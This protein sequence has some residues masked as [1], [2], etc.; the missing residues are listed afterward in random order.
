M[1]LFLK[2]C[3]RQ[4]PSHFGIT[5]ILLI[6]SLLSG[7]GGGVGGTG[8]GGDGGGGSGGGGVGGTGIVSMGT[9]K[10][11]E[12]ATI[13]VNNTAYQITAE[14]KVTLDGKGAPVTDLQ[15]G[16]VVEVDAYKYTDTQ[17]TEAEVIT[18]KNTL[19]GPIS[20]ING[21]CGSMVVLGQIIEADTHTLPTLVNGLCDYS[22]GEIVEVSGYVSDTV[23]N[24]IRATFIRIKAASQKVNMSGNI[25]SVS[26]AQKTFVIGALT[27]DYA[28]AEFEPSNAVPAVGRFARVSGIATGFDTVAATEVEMN[29]EGLGGNAGNEAE[30]TGFVS[31]L[32]GTTFTVNGQA[33]NASKAKISPETA[34]LANSVKVEV[35]GKLN[36]QSEI[37]ASEIEVKSTSPISIQ[38]NVEAISANGLTLSGIAILVNDSTLF[39]DESGNTSKLKL[40]DIRPNDQV[41][42][43]CYRDANGNLVARKVELKTPS[44][45]FT[46]EGDVVS[47]QPSGYSFSILAGLDITVVIGNL[48]EIKSHNGRLLS[49]EEFLALLNPGSRVKAEGVL[50]S[51]KSLDAT[52][53]KVEIKD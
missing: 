34:T 22:I 45:K 11:T 10:K 26:A 23:L 15:P 39:Q 36:T 46:V 50:G 20:S 37:D 33:I 24:A 42:I 31:N 19:T 35:H 49:P 41:T 30:V 53:G 17:I 6:G 47:V 12:P 32:S 13:T 16:M 21:N 38:S 29:P 48:T 43:S 27:I 7:C 9:V 2:L 51:A 25:A 5:L 1:V 52:S 40:A 3:N 18:Y 4:L 44:T 8:G 14:T 28:N